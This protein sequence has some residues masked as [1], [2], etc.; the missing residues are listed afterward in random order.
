MKEDYEYPLMPEWSK[1]EII[2]MVQ[3]YAQV[4]DAYT[5]GVARDKFMKMVRKF[6][7]IEPS[8]AAQKQ[9]DRKF[10]ELSGYS[11]YQAIKTVSNSSKE[12]VK[13]EK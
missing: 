6:K 12:R 9:L 10:K 2:A 7:T 3:F 5:T 13:V 8:I 4:E 11:I 1:D